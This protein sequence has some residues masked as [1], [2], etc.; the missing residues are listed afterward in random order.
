[1]PKESQ[2]SMLLKQ[3]T[4]LVEACILDEDS[5]SDKSDDD[6]LDLY[7]LIVSNRYAV[8]RRNHP[9]AQSNL[10]YYLYH[11]PPVEFLSHFRLTRPFFF[12]LV[13]LIRGLSEFVI[14]STSDRALE[15]YLLVFLKYVGTMGTGG[16][17][18]KLATFF[19]MGSGSI[20]AIVNATMNLVL[21]LKS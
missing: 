12:S 10:V 18:V 1:M 15:L 19:S 11:M 21:Q 4:K 14:S 20:D 8:P 6:Y 5:D 2:R 3:A 17:F 13:E 7:A 16:S 9:R